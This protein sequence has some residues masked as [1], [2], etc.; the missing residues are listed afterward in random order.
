MSEHIPTAIR[1]LVRERANGC[2][3]YC[4]LHEDDALLTYEADHIIA[5]KH[6]GATEESNL[7]WT[8]FVC[9]R[10]KGSDISSIDIETGQLVGL[11]NP[12][13]DRWGDHFE[14]DDNGKIVPL[15]DVGRVTEY[16][17]RLNRSDHLDHRKT[18]V[19]VKRC[20]KQ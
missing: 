8:C 6:R 3:E 19:R 12:R 13:T 15:T 9:N 1:R 7:A 20:P 16:L 4:L 11:F 14:L 5:T 18:L 2:C 17:L 10:A